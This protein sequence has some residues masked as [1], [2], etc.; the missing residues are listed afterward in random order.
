VNAVHV[1]S[2]ACV[3]ALFILAPLNIV[4]AEA[5][6]A[7]AQA[8]PTAARL[9]ID[10]GAFVNINGVEQW[11][12]IRGT[13]LSNPALL[14]LH[15]GPGMGQAFMAPAFAAWEKGFT[16][17]QWDQPGGG[18]TQLKN[19]D[20]AGPMT[21]ERFR[22]DGLAVTQYALKR[23]HQRKLVL[24]GNSWGTLLGI[25]M[26]KARPELFS[27]YVGS[28]QAVGD[29][30]NKLGYELA[31]KAA[32]ERNDATA[33]AA[34]EKVGPPPYEKFEDF[35]TRQQYSN[36][37]ALPPSAAEV[38]ANAE[39]WSFMATPPPADAKYLAPLPMLSPADMWMNFVETQKATFKQTW[40]WEARALG[41]KFSMPVFI[42]QGELDINTPA[43]TARRYYQDIK[44]PKKGFELIAGA[45]HNTIAF[46]KELLRLITRD[47]RPLVIEGPKVARR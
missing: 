39:T 33:I 45:G 7:L 46:Q 26:V 32:R 27:A 24:V 38:A 44:A 2:Q 35:F 13:N 34:L 29:E 43:L 4:Q 47:V 18:F 17:V 16:L 11:I 42:Y 23:L 12:T 20:N 5:P 25:E 21:I 3:A 19:R 31:L 37:P 1:I 36:P 6:A 28:S 40:S 22:K 14:F 9:A 8:A 30:G 41:M 10:E 15:G